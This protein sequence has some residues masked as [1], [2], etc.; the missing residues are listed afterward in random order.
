MLLHLK[1]L[2]FA[3]SSRRFDFRDV[4]REQLIHQR[5]AL[6]ERQG[7]CVARASRLIFAAS[8]AALGSTGATS[9]SH[10]S[11][12]SGCT[13]TAS[14]ERTVLSRERNLGSGEAVH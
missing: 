12:A 7:G 13:S 4:G 6:G 3:P 8:A 1:R 9:A 5:R 14:S 11:K 10:L 2:S